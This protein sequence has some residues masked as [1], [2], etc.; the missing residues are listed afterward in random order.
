MT[1]HKIGSREEWMAA[2]KE[3]LAQ[4]KELTKMRDA[5]AAERRAL[6]WVKLEENY[7][8]DSVK[9]KLS[10]SDLFDG[11]SQLHVQHFM[12]GPDWKAGCFGCSFMADHVDGARQHFEHNDLSFV[13][14]SRTGVEQIEA[15]KK[16]MGWKF[17]WV[18]SL[19]SD[20]N[21]DFHVSFKRAN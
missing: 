16:R 17:N 11:R 12:F 2:R 7:V 6:P 18:S 10:L 3:L 13:A 21:Y 8:F 15:Y 14:V 1:T 19:G 9:G 20:F 4:E 5:V